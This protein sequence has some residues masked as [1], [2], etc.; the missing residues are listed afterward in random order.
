M[1]CRFYRSF[2]S[3]MGRTIVK[4]SRSLKKFTISL[5]I[6][7]FFSMESDEPLCSFSAYSK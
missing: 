4:Q 7:F 2:S 5:R 3:S 6:L 1:N